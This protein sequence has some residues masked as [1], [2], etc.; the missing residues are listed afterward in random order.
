MSGRAGLGARAIIRVVAWCAAALV[1]TACTVPPPSAPPAALPEDVAQVSDLVSYY[2]RVAAMTPADQSREYAA[3]G[4]ALSRDPTPYNRVRVALLAS[5]PG[6][7]FQDDVRAQSLLEPYSQAGPGYD[8]LRQFAAL[9]HGQLAERSKAR[10]RADQLKEQL[11]ALRAVER[12]IIERTQP[13]PPA[14][15]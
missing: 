6:T 5:M 3:A 15:R 12:T 1:Q 11:D 10:A 4:Q 8:R 7:T 9:L 14:K 13:A 2:A